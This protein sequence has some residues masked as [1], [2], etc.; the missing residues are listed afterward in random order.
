MIMF[1]INFLIVLVFYTNCFFMHNLR[2]EDLLGKQI[3]CAEESLDAE[4]KSNTFER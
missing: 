3:S 2:F 1:L 4:F